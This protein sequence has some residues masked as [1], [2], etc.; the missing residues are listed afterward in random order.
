[1]NLQRFMVT[2][3]HGENQLVI[4][5]ITPQGRI[6]KIKPDDRKILPLTFTLH[7][8]LTFLLQFLPSVRLLG[9]A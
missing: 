8:D 3:S 4:P 2:I 5:D 1:M 7:L 6:L 9:L